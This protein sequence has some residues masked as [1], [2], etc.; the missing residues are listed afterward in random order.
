MTCDFRSTRAFGAH[1][2]ILTGVILL[3]ACGPAEPPPASSGPPVTPV[4]D[5]QSGRLEALL[6]DADGDGRDET[7]AVMDGSLLQRV[8]IDRD[9]DGTPDRIESY[10]RPSPD[11]SGGAPLITRAEER[12]HTGRLVRSEI[13]E[14]GTI[15]RVEED[16]DG[17]GRIDKWEYYQDGTLMRVDLDLTGRGTPDRRLLYGAGGARRV[18]V[19]PEGDGVFEPQP[20]AGAGPAVP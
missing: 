18:E 12:D 15:V 10:D 9:G 4:Y 11:R 6:S 13:Y 17:D 2:L 16:T 14:Q 19:D 5:P 20:S 3:A 8:E 1:A 7:R